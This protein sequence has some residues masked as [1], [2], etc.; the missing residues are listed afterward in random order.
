MRPEH[1]LAS[2]GAMQYGI[3]LFVVARVY[4][5]FYQIDRTESNIVEQVSDDSFGI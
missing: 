3:A 2:E 4:I 5:G 1:Q